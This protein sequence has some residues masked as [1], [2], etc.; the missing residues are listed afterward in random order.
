MRSLKFAAG[1]AA[2]LIAAGCA[3]Q[4]TESMQAAPNPRVKFGKPISN[5]DIA[6]WDI[7][8]R[9]PDGKG[10]PAG[11]GTAAQ[12]KAVYDAKCVACH[13]PEAKGGSVYGTMVGGIGSFKT[14]T[15]V[16]TPGSMYPYAP[17]LFDY[18]RR[19][20]PMDRPQS[21]TANEVYALSAYILNLN[22]IIPESAV[23]DQTTLA[24]VQ[25]PNRNGFIIDDRP[26]TKAARCM[27]NCR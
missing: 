18:I 3:T 22:G 8:I 24:Q 23:M 1:L 11:S 21:L 2:A 14:S 12:G 16:V 5:A 26:D 13:G 17:I 10:L 7:D 4:Q 9:T 6:P 20:M 25:M 27:T 15:R 19:A